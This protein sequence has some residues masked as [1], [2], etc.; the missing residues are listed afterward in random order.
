MAVELLVKAGEHNRELC[1]VKVTMEAEKLGKDVKSCTLVAA[2]SGAKRLGSAKH[3]RMA[4]PSPYRGYWIAWKPA[5]RRNIRY[6]QRPANH[7]GLHWITWK[8]IT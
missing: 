2:D 8:A 5:L 3:Q 1:P 7:L 4:R 6:Q